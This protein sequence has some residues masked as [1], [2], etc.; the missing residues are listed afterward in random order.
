MY[1]R[2]CNDI[3]EKSKESMEAF[4][5]FLCQKTLNF[6]IKV[7]ESNKENKLLQGCFHMNYFLDGE[8]IAVGVVD[9]FEEGL[10]SVYFFYEP[11][12]QKYSLG[13]VAAVYEIEYIQKMSA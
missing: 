5:G 13:V 12:Y 4:K 10:S 6:G 1:Q 9:M 3:H 7:S 8:F 2:Y 11:K